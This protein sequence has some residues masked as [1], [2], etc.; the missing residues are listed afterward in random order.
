MGKDSIGG[1]MTQQIDVNQIADALNNKIDLPN[2]KNQ[3]DVDYVVDF[4]NPTAQ[5]NYT[6]YRLYKSG[7]V[8]QGSREL[9]SA[10]GNNSAWAV[11]YTL[12]IEM[13]DNNYTATA[14]GSFAGGSSWN[15]P[16]I[17]TES[18]STTVT[19]TGWVTGSSTAK[20]VSWVVSGMSEQGGS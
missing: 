10:T 17:S 18:T 14:N 13:A 12:P 1:I 6:W 9:K 7:W 16:Y 15:G 2:G 4:Q 8:E 20:V 11:S 19:F 5:N 3:S